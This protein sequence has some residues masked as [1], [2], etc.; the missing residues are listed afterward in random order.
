VLFAVLIVS[1][2][3]WHAFIDVETLPTREGQSPACFPILVAIYLLHLML[4]PFVFFRHN[5]QLRSD[6]TNDNNKGIGVSQLNF[7][8]QYRSILRGL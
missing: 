6:A 3:A 5:A 2:G 7:Q 1:C 4:F 8:R